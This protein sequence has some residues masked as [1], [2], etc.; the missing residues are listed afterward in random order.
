MLQSN[1]YLLLCCKIFSY[2]NI[3]YGNQNT[4]KTMI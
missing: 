2:E 4:F 1:T 3:N